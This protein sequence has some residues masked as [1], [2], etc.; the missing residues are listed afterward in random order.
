VHHHTYT[1]NQASDGSNSDGRTT[2]PT[3]QNALIRLER[4]SV[5]GMR[6]QFW[7][8]PLLSSKALLIHSLSQLWSSHFHLRPNCCEL[9]PL[10]QVKRNSTWWKW[11][12]S[13]WFLGERTTRP[14]HT[15][16]IQ[17]I[18]VSSDRE[19]I[20]SGV[21]LTGQSAPSFNQGISHCMQGETHHE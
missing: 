12:D 3:N 7:R 18:S 21:T 9:S 17:T 16:A 2:R 20:R 5:A 10:T 6:L 19:A 13:L 8:R 1:Q 15:R 4:L 11:P 14:T